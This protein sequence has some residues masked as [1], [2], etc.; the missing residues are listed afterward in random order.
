MANLPHAAA[1][2]QP[3]DVEVVS[4]PD[5]GGPR[6]LHSR[7]DGQTLELSWSLREDGVAVLVVRALAPHAA[8][9][10]LEEEDSVT[11]GREHKEGGVSFLGTVVVIQADLGLKRLSF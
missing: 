1:A 5:T 2:L 11:D 9:E 3:H 4:E 10:D 8:H 6:E 7:D